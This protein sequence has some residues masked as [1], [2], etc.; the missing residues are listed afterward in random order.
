M[1][2]VSVWNELK[3]FYLPKY[4]IRIQLYTYSNLLNSIL[5]LSSIDTYITFHV[6]GS[7]VRFRA[8]RRPEPDPRFGSDFSRLGNRATELGFYWSVRRTKSST[9]RLNREPEPSREKKGQL[10][11][12]VAGSE[13]Q[14]HSLSIIGQGQEIER[15][16]IRDVCFVFVL[17]PRSLLVLRAPWL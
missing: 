12:S 16:A 17:V 1:C 13:E 11:R 15:S 14:N 9:E 5:R 10:R 7:P 2:I 4:Y 6:A 8:L 3:T